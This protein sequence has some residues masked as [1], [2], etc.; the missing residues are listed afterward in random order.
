VLHNTTRFCEMC[1]RI[2]GLAK[3]RV[4][5]TL[6]ISHSA[7]LASSLS[8]LAADSKRSIIIYMCRIQG[9]TRTLCRWTMK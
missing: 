7:N 3:A 4:A 2:D 9:S 8:V 5:C 6:A 1:Q